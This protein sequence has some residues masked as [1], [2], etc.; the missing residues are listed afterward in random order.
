[1][2]AHIRSV[3]DIVGLFDLINV[4]RHIKAVATSNRLTEGPVARPSNPMP[5]PK[6]ITTESAGQKAKKQKKE[7]K[8]KKDQQ[9]SFK[10]FWIKLDE[11]ADA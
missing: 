10:N 5:K 7:E 8:N 1:M 11:E 4:F 2:R 6:S 9:A 3:M